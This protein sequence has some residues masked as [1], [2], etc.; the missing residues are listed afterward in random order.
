ME[1]R[2][3]L[4]PL[5]PGATLLHIGLP[6]TGT[7]AIQTAATRLRAELLTQ[8]VCYP[9]R[10][11]NHIAAA[12]A[13]MGRA[14]RI[15]GLRP[16]RQWTD[17]HDELRAHPECI[18]WLSY[19]QMVQA[20]PAAIERF[21]DELG[22]HTHAVI[23]ARGYVPMFASAWQ[24]WIKDAGDQEFAVWLDA[25]LGDVPDDGPVAGFWRRHDLPRV[26]GRWADVLGPENVTVVV[27]DKA[28]PALLFDSFEALLG[29]DRGLLASV[30][31]DALQDNRTLSRMEAE[32]VCG[33][34]AIYEG[35]DF[36]PA[37][38]VY[39]RMMK[40]GTVATLQRCRRAQ[41]AEGR[42]VA[43]RDAAERIARRG[44]HA[45]TA[46]RELGVR[47]VGDVRALGA[48]P[49]SLPD[50]PARPFETMEV[51]LTAL[52]IVGAVSAALGEGVGFDARSRRVQ[53][54]N[55]AVG[56]RA[57]SEELARRPLRTARD[58]IA[59]VWAMWRAQ[60]RTPEGRTLTRSEGAL[61]REVR[62]RLREPA[63]AA[64][65]DAIAQDALI[66]A[67]RRVEPDPG[68]GLSAASAAAALAGALSWLAGRGVAYDEDAGPGLLRA[69]GAAANAS[70]TA[71]DLDS[72]TLRR[73]VLERARRRM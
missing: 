51:D 33:A 26:A 24:Q 43:H 19:E 64:A 72:G 48:V 12:N 37:R 66:L 63:A 65:R 21:R 45:A 22:P 10:G 31:R 70:V 4:R 29:L 60:A 28:E 17:V 40:S 62:S 3:R 39:F 15:A 25:V 68:G 30:P 38:D 6:K 27:L 53:Q 58:A 52:A 46:L 2:A 67:M 49:D 8:G 57:A 7:T 42:I 44:R 69:K 73:I 9:G 36:P 55:W 11:S 54:G 61:V 47:V 13:L 16:I 59:D 20:D 41:P 18:G 23:T 50:A 35:G 5:E 14:T 71:R 32:L 56:G 1:A 34:N